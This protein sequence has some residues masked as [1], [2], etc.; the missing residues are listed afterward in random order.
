LLVLLFLFFITSYSFGQYKSSNFSLVD[1]RARNIAVTTPEQL[2]KNLTAPY[3][4]DLDKVR[5]IFIWITENIQYNDNPWRNA[6]LISSSK[7]HM[8]DASDTGALKP[9]CERVALDVLSRGFAFCDGYSRLFKTLCDYAGIKS[10]VI[11]GYGN[12][13]GRRLKFNSNHRWNAVYIDSSWHLLDVTWASGHIGYGN[14]Y[15]KHYNDYYFLTP[16]R[17][18]AR[19]HFPEE[20]QWT[21][22][23]EPFAI[24]E[25]NY[26]PFKTHS[27]FKS[28]IRSYFPKKG[29]IEA[30]VGDTL[31]FEMEGFAD[32][33]DL[34]VLDQTNVDSA[35][36]ADAIR[37]DTVGSNRI[38]KGNKTT[39]Q[40][41]VSSPSV[42]W[43]HIIY[44]EEMIMRYKINVRKNIAGTTPTDQK[45]SPTEINN[46]F[47]PSAPKP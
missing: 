45:N 21:L 36:I 27:F 24:M 28:N 41:T 5:S 30:A 17:E 12:G 6:S 1:N 9:L 18:F 7:D 20:L 31:Q 34:F 3:I 35:I 11:T 37:T 32:T 25:L 43:L 44:K 19:D 42:Q 29:V 38:I 33:K 47:D 10:E 39:Y 14:Q 15:I 16:A 26:A 8:D 4:T 22:L 46:P 13:G 2:A 40:Y 23:D